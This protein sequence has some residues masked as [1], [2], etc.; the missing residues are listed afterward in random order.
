MQSFQPRLPERIPQKLRFIELGRGLAFIYFKTCSRLFWCV[1]GL[2]ATDPIAWAWNAWLEDL[3][4][5]LFSLALSCYPGLVTQ[6][7]IF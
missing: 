2:E 7:F 6:P 4:P 1:A 5:S 3:G